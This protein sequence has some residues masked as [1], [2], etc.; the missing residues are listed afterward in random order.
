MKKIIIS[1][2]VITCILSI[3]GCKKNKSDKTFPTTQNYQKSDVSSETAKLENM[4]NLWHVTNKRICV[5]FGY[6]FN[7]EETVSKITSMLEQRYG[8]DDDDGLIYP[9]VYPDSFKRNGRSFSSEFYSILSESEKDFAGIVIIGA[10]ETTHIAL[11]RL[12]DFWE[13]N[14]PYPII[15][16]FPQDDVLGLESTC[17]I[18]I[19]KAQKSEVTEE[20]ED[21]TAPAADDLSPVLLMNTIDYV[22]T[23]N[24][25][26]PKNSDLQIHAQQMLKN[27]TITKYTDPD[28]GLKSINH[29]VLA[30]N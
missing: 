29:F 22:L 7:D 10:P 28:T 19:E 2:L 27:D 17:D 4:I 12:Q 18:V 21:E 14:I 5:L 20:V 9:L 11:G 25:P 16:L 3:S 23:L 30:A 6:G 1:I 13:M 8:L 24:G 26:I 15:A